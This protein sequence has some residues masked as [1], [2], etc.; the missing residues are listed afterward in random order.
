[1][2]DG[3]RRGRERRAW[4]ERAR[5]IVRQPGHQP[6]DGGLQSG[7][8]IVRSF[9]NFPSNAGDQFNPQIRNFLSWRVHARTSMRAIIRQPKVSPSRTDRAGG[10]PATRPAISESRHTFRSPGGGDFKLKCRRH[11]EVPEKTNGKA[12]QSVTTNRGLGGD[13]HS[14]GRT[15]CRAVGKSLSS[16]RARTFSSHQGDQTGLR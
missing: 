10:T 1:M 9:V 8:T 6:L 3:S 5:S 13:S 15:H 14:T 16:G 7:G 2:T 11:R 12:G 4:P